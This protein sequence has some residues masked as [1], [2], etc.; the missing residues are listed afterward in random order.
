MNHKIIDFEHVKSGGFLSLFIHHTLS[1]FSAYNCFTNEKLWS[2]HFIECVDFISSPYIPFFCVCVCETALFFFVLRPSPPPPHFP[3]WTTRV[4]LLAPVSY[5]QYFSRNL[6][7]KQTPIR[8][9]GLQL[10]FNG[11]AFGGNE[12]VWCI[13]WVLNCIRGCSNRMP[14]EY[15]V[16][17][18]Q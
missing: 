16:N 15:Y 12:V 10:F 1:D 5:W 7:E 6:N 2:R 9:L 14:F 13:G 8:R 17:V 3:F 18:F 4:R 11:P